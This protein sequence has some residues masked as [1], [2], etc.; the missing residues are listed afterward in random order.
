MREILHIQGGQCGNQIGA[1]FWEVYSCAL[2]IKLFKLY[3]V[4]YIIFLH[5]KVLLLMYISKCLF[6]VAGSA[7]T[8]FLCNM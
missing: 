6:G 4:L 2:Q 1:K 8:E 5:F 7:R 3:I